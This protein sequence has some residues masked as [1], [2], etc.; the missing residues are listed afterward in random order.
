[1]PA[2][3]VSHT[4]LAGL[5]L[6]GGIGWIMRKYGLTVDSLESADLVTADG[7]F[8]R[9]SQDENADLFWGLRGGGGN[10]GVVTDF[11]FRLHPLGPQVMAGATFWSMDAAEDVLRAY[12]DWIAECPDELTTIVVQ[13]LAPA[14]PVVP[15]ELVGRPVIAVV[16]CYA[17]D[18]DEG[19]EVL[20]P[21]RGF[22]SPV[23]DLFAPKQFVAH[24]QMFNPSF[25]HGCWYYVRSCDVAELTDEVIGVV[26][27][28]GRLISSPMS[29]IALWQ[30]GGAVARVA[31]DATAFSG[32]S[33]GFTFNINGNTA[34]ADGFEDQR[35]WARDYWTALTPFHTGVYVNFLMEEGGARVRQAY[36]DAKYQRLSALKR[37]YDPSNF[38]RLN[39]NIPPGSTRTSPR[40]E[41]ERSVQQQVVCAP[42]R[43]D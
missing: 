22:G 29:S 42:H 43:P 16:A 28:Y 15:A 32:R 9:A 23:L 1:V 13:R 18:V 36:G 34:T 21:M 8:V 2:G 40:A 14:L 27:E 20:R 6:G 33:A 38:F 37:K 10:F 31:D 39:Q 30:M 35:Q 12:R 26:A 5:T 17:G 25:R 4:G 24:Q 11:R 19:K 41:P 7:E 3:I